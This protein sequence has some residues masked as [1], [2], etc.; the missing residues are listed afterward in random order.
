MTKKVLMMVT[1]VAIATLWMTVPAKRA[2]VQAQPANMRIVSER[3]AVLSSFFD[4]MPAN[5]MLAPRDNQTRSQAW[6]RRSLDRIASS[7]L[8]RFLGLSPLPVYAQNSCDTN[9]GEASGSYNCP[10]NCGT[11][12]SITD[13]GG[14]DYCTGTVWNGLASTTRTIQGVR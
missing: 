11:T 5:K 3:G 6:F 12:Q 7:E 14:S 9:N 2:R 8:F 10:Y 4:G 1:A 13:N